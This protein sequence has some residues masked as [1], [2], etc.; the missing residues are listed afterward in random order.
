MTAARRALAAD[1]AIVLAAIAAAWVL[2]RWVIFPAFGIP[3]NA[4]Y[5]L[6]PIF[7]FFAAWS[8]LRWRREGWSSVGLRKPASWWRAAA[9]AIALYL[10]NLAVSTWV[11]PAAAQWLHPTQA[12]PFLAYIRGNLPAF[13]EWVAIGCIVG[14]WFEECLFRG[15]LLDRVANV[16]GG[17]AGA[18]GVAVVAQAVLFGALHLYGGSFAFLYATLFAL[19]HAVF[20][21][22]AGRNL[23]PLIVVH[24]AWNTAGMWQV[25]A[26]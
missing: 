25:Y 23:W 7:G 4:P 5:I 14:G 19:V 1:L 18:V 16:L 6:R 3:D 22:L 12:P 21:V 13:L 24:A 10:A 17:G 15:F 9:V 2:S 11:V 8:V 26:G 20:F